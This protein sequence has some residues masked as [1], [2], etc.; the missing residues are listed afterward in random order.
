[1]EKNY[2]VDLEKLDKLLGRV[3][4]A[5]FIIADNETFDDHVRARYRSIG[6]ELMFVQQLIRDPAFFTSMWDLYMNDE[7]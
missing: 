4:S 5:N 1:M 7:V 2:N 3:V 6:S